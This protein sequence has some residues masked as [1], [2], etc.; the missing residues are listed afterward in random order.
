MSKPVAKRDMEDILHTNDDGSLKTEAID[1]K[2]SLRK[3]ALEA[4]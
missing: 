3:K 2:T 1:K 4:S